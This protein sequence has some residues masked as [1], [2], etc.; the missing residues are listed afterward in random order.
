MFSLNIR[1]ETLHIEIEM[2]LKVLKEFFLKSL[3]EQK[4]N[5]KNY[6]SVALQSSNPKINN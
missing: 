3:L 2:P 5:E 1:V 4:G 6:F